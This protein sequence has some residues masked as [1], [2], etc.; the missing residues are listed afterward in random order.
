MGSEVQRD[1][2]MDAVLAGPSIVVFR[3][4]ALGWRRKIRVLHHPRLGR[5]EQPTS[6]LARPGQARAHD[7]GITPLD[8]RTAD[9][10]TDEL[11]RQLGIAAAWGRHELDALSGY[12]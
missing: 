10:G 1:L 6:C 2:R 3:Q 11:N 9:L 7:M 8:W 5:T 12:L 4:L